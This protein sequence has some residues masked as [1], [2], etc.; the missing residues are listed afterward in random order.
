MPFHLKRTLF[1]QKQFFAKCISHFSLLLENFYHISP[2]WSQTSYFVQLKKKK[3]A[4]E[5]ANPYGHLYFLAKK[6]KLQANSFETIL[7]KT[8]ENT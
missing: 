5:K 3:K 7:V 8:V 1:I 2:E 4:G 6:K